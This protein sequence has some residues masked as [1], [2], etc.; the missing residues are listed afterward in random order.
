MFD[1]VFWRATYGQI[2]RWRRN[3]LGLSSTNLDKLEPHK[4]PFL[5]NF[6][7]TVVPPPLDWPEWIRVTGY[8]FL[9]DADVSAN[10]WT[11]PQGLVKFIDNA[12]LHGKKVVYIGFGSI[13]VSDPEAM[14][15]CVVEA[16]VQSGVYAILS[17]G[18][19]D[20]LQTKKDASEPEVPLPPQIYSVKSV[21]HDWLFTRIE[22]ACHHG[23]A[24]TTGASLR[25]GI[26]TIIKPFFGD[27]FFWGDRV[28]ALGIGTCV[29]KLTVD[30]L[31]D[32]LIQAT[33]DEKQIGKAKLVGEKIRSVSAL[34]F[35][36]VP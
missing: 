15:R 35:D 25:A 11:P 21:P 7:P 8:W 9:D 30:S 34:I 36:L 28:E 14:T 23:G 10:K 2:N 12:H 31:A 16:I 27:Q 6:S 17:K 20:R 4:V 1:Q 33:T 32:A 22:A 13:V 3:T 19:S 26:P 18:W 29:R 24:G 5:Y